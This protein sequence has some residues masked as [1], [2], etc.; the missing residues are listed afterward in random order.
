LLDRVAGDYEDKAMYS[1]SWLWLFIAD[2]FIFCDK[3]YL[4]I[5]QWG[6]MDI[7]LICINTVR[8]IVV[9]VNLYYHFSRKCIQYDIRT[10]I[11]QFHR[12]K[13]WSL[14]I[15]ARSEECTSEN[16]TKIR[17]AMQT[18]M[19]MNFLSPYFVFSKIQVST[20]THGIN[21]QSR[22]ITLVKDV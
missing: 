7:I 15:L 6:N 2:N 1:S 5:S 17:P 12:Y 3:I 22:S 14:F 4:A 10:V 11:V 16:T 20:M 18:Q 19:P 21:Q 8:W 13:K 9:V